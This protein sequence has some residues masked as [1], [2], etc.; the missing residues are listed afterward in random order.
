MTSDAK[1]GLLLGLVFIF[2]IAFIING[3]PGFNKNTNNNELSTNMVSFEN[4][5]PGLAA[6]ERKA[7]KAFE[8]ATPVKKT[9]AELQAQPKENNLRFTAELSKPTLAVKDVPNIGEVTSV[10]PLTAVAKEA[11]Y[12]VKSSGPALPKIYVVTEGDS[13]AGIAKKVYGSQYGN[14]QINITRIF[15]AN[16]G[17]LKSP[18]EIYV[19]QRLV[20]PPLSEPQSDEDKI[21]RLLYPA[22]FERAESTGPAEENRHHVVQEG[23][24][25][26]QIAAEELDDGTRYQEIAELNSGIL[27]DED[28]LVV[29]MCLKLPKR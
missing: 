18:D 20:I 8:S 27:E 29:G 11:N 15:G 10:Q 4:K 6:K 5:P 25:L 1:I 2:L 19:G 7:Q 3:M 22:S 13:L 17:I 14:K 24:S 28:N 12:K 9:P 21:E 26:W 16:R 23:D